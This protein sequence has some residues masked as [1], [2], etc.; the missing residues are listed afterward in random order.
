MMRVVSRAK[1]VA[2][3]ELC[4]CESAR[5]CRGT[6]IAIICEMASATDYYFILLPYRHV[7]TSEI[8]EDICVQ[9]QFAGH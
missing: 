7:A 5:V 6:I 1:K 4:C 2:A 8:S 3:T 9:Y